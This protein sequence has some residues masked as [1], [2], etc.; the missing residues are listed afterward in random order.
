MDADE[1][2]QFE[3]SRRELLDVALVQYHIG[4]K[5]D[6]DTEKIILTGELDAIVDFYGDWRSE[7]EEVL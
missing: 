1:R 3:E 7:I 4:S 2:A 5:I 6:P